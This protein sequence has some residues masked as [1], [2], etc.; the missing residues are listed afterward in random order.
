MSQSNPLTSDPAPLASETTAG[1]EP[2]AVVDA[3]STPEGVQ[4]SIETL[5]ER[6]KRLEA[7]AAGSRKEW[8]RERAERQR[9]EAE[10][11]AMRVYLTQQQQVMQQ[12]SAPQS[13]PEDDAASEI[14]DAVIDGDKK[15]IATALR[16]QRDAAAYEAQQRMAGYM[17][18]AAQ[19]AQGFQSLQGYMARVGVT[20][21]NGPLAIKTTERFNSI[22]RD[23]NYAFTGGNPQWLMTIAVNE[24]RAELAKDGAGSK[25]E[26]RKQAV[27]ESF[28]EPSKSTG[29]TP[30]KPAVS[31]TKMY[32]TPDEMKWVEY[33]VRKGKNRDETVKRLWNALRPEDRAARLEAK[34]A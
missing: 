18:Q 26:G 7:N 27:S 24:A 10:A 32:L 20:D 28:S 5:Q 9:I 15:R 30:G 13:A 3:D 2:G 1:T 17:G 16:K 31:N 34:R 23:P 6:I 29:S 8:E 33:D 14:Y 19:Q 11:Q 12:Q 21:P 4:P 25:E 22:A